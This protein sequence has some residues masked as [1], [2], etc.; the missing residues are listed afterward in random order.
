MDATG[1]SPAPTDESLM[2]GVQ[3]G[4]PGALE[5][6]YGRHSASAQRV[7]A[8]IC[9]DEGRA[10]DVVQEAFIAVWRGREGYRPAG[11]FK[12]WL[13][14]T[15]RNR[16]LDRI[17]NDSAKKRPP[18]PAYGAAI[19]RDES[20]SGPLSELILHEENEALRIALGH[21][22]EAQSAI[23]ELAFFGGFTHDEIS[24]RLDL[25][26]GT[27]K[28]RMRLGLEKM[29]RQVERSPAFED[30]PVTARDAA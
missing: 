3:A 28:G 9:H 1:P 23:V 10:Q 25:P 21:L 15:V 4:Q 17:R 18:N 14:R 11:S 22:P 16:A 2:L 27:V 24:S 8:S 6:L 19:A 20:A 5:S 30:R 12:S 13:L 7:A 26:V 29:R